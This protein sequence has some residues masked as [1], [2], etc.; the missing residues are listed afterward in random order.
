MMN[1]REF[2]IEGITEILQN[3]F[4][5]DVTQFITSKNL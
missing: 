5:E 4:D 3:V 1:L 2:S